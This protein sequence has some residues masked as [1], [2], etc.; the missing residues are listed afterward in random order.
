MVKGFLHLAF[1]LVNC[2]QENANQ[3]LALSPHRGHHVLGETLETLEMLAQCW[4]VICNISH[5]LC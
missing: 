1:V 3:H 2:K 4:D 5:L